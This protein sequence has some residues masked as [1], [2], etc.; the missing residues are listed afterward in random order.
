[1]MSE[2]MIRY[3][4]LFAGGL[5]AGTF[6]L[7]ALSSK[8]AK[9]LYT[10]ALATALRCKDSVITSL[11]RAQAAAEDILSDAKELNESR[12]N[13]ESIIKDDAETGDAQ[14]A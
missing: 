13:A 7:K 2:K 1:M 14:E 12:Q 9:H 5:F 4:A 6:G 11:K 8:D 10:N 3:L